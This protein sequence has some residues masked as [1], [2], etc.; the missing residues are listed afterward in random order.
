M[1]YATKEK[2]GQI[3]L[4]KVLKICKS[5]DNNRKKN[6]LACGRKYLKIIY[7]NID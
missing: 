4:D 7:M 3:R 1:V 5:K 6:N 2:N